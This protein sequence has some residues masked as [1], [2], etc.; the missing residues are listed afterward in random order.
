MG[1]PEPGDPRQG[2]DAPGCAPRAAEPPRRPERVARSERGA[3]HARWMG[4]PEGGRWRG[5]GHK[6]GPSGDTA[7]WAKPAVE[8]VAGGPARQT[9]APGVSPVASI[10]PYPGGC[11][12]SGRTVPHAPGAAPAA[13]GAHVPRGRAPGALRPGRSAPSGR[14]AAPVATGPRSP[15]GR[16]PSRLCP[17]SCVSSK[18]SK[19]AARPGPACPPRAG[20]SSAMRRGPRAQA[21]GWAWGPGLLSAGSAHVR[22]VGL[23]F[24]FN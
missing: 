1:P 5:K 20:G 14:R 17:P 9:P 7:G 23:C 10:P 6:F 13:R 22:A 4:H 19:E 11:G 3:R 8:L 12:S 2:S 21:H 16:D 15:L 18:F 24:V